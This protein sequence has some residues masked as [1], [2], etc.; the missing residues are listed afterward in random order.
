MTA[1]LLLDTCTAL[2]VVAGEGMSKSAESVLL[3]AYN[4]GVPVYLSPISAWE[5]GMLASKGRFKSSLTPQRWLEELLARPTIR[6]AEM[7]ASLLIESSFL[8]GK[9]LRDPVDRIIAA[10]A[11]EYGF[12]VVT[13]DRALLD[14]AEQGYLNA[15]PC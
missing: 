1:P 15:L 14:Y 5:I 7:N 13:R 4:A 11:R 9:R 10:T 6:F 3:D 12:T 2:W 8:P